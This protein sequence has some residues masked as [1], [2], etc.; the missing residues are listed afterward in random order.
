MGFGIDLTC[1]SLGNHDVVKW[2]M[3]FVISGLFPRE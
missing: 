2:G 3:I 1:F